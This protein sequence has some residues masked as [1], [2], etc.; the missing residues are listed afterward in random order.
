MSGASDNSLNPDFIGY[1]PPYPLS[2]LS[3]EETKFFMQLSFAE[4][5]SD[6]KIDELLSAQQPSYRILSSRL[7]AQ[8]PSAQ[9]TAC[10]KALAVS[11]CVTPGHCVV[12]AWTLAKWCAEH[13]RK[14]T[15]QELS[16]TWWDMGLPDMNNP[17]NTIQWDM[18]KIG[19]K[20]GLDV[21]EWVFK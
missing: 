6:E 1:A 12:M 19:G 15:I 14:A 17:M 7:Q 9:T 3:A 5:N 18:Q 8:A 13:K 4:K 10:L 2:A 20:N 16:C 21:T 11:R